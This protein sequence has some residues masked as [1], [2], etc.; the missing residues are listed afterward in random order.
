MLSPDFWKILDQRLVV[1]AHFLEERTRE[2]RDTAENQNKTDR[3]I[4]EAKLD[5]FIQLMTVFEKLYN[6]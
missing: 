6:H 1:Y 3:Q 5:R 2:G 4:Y